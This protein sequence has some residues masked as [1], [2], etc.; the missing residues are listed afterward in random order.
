MVLILA[1][2][3]LVLQ[4]QQRRWWVRPIFARRAEQGDYSNLFQELRKDEDKFFA[5]C[6][7]T[8][9]QFDMLLN[10]VTPKLLKNSKRSAICPGERLA[11]TLR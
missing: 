2:A 3:F 9:A 6:R 7:M 4:R 5:Y 10:M 1:A 8:T 11:L